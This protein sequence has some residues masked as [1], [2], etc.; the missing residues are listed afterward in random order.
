MSILNT[1][2]N[3]TSSIKNVKIKSNTRQ[4]YFCISDYV[5]QS[6]LVN[7]KSQNLTRQQYYIGKLYFLTVLS[8]NL[9]CG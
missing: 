3:L 6:F 9:Y 5:L 1:N 7:T 8:T 4:N 2:I